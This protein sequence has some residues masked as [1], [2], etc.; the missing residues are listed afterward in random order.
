[1]TD[2]ITTE[3]KYL[4]DIKLNE[5]LDKILINNLILNEIHE[6]S[7]FNTNE[8]EISKIFE[9]IINFLWNEKTIEISKYKVLNL[10]IIKNDQD[11]LE[12]QNSVENQILNT[13]AKY[14]SQEVELIKTDIISKNK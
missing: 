9:S 6:I 12:K 8:Q 10:S 13:F 7:I 1:M 4:F 5:S 2:L 3:N 14:F 11:S